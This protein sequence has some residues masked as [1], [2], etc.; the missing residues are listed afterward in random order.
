MT[1]TITK[2]QA[3]KILRTLRQLDPTATMHPTYSGR[4]MYG[5]ECIGFSARNGA[6]VGTA[7]AIALAGTTIDVMALVETACTDDL[8]L[9]EIVYFPSTQIGA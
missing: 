4:F 1:N 5:Q 2:A 7:V 9:D 8:A 6:H 3:N